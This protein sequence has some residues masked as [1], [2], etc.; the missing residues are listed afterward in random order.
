[1]DSNYCESTR[2]EYEQFLYIVC[3]VS[4]YLASFANTLLIIIII[5]NGFCSIL[6]INLHSNYCEIIPI[7]VLCFVI[8]HILKSTKYWNVIMLFAN[9]KF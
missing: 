4:V 8:Y 1:M 9:A 3:I 5:T 6:I 7:I 2:A